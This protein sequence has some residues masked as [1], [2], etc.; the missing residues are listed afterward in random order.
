MP[1]DLSGSA[2][3]GQG[4]NEGVPCGK[5]HGAAVKKIKV[6]IWISKTA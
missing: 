6:V 3:S 5:E 2:D 4:F 1:E